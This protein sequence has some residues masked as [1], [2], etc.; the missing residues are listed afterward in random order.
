VSVW[1]PRSWPVLSKSQADAAA[2]SYA[3]VRSFWADTASASVPVYCVPLSTPGPNPVTAVP[4][5][6][7]RSPLMTVLPVLVT[8]LPAR[9]AKVVAVPNPG[10]VEVSAAIDFVPTTRATNAAASTYRR[11]RFTAQRV[12]RRRNEAPHLRSQVGRYRDCVIR[13]MNRLAFTRSAAAAGPRS[14][15][16]VLRVK[17]IHEL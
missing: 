2:A 12:T 5:L 17:G 8:V 13:A 6:T 15:P 16:L 4:G 10:A 9:T 7:P 14:G 11:I 3:V 1:P